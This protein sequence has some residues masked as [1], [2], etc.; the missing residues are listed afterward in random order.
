[1]LN[2]G[3]TAK[4]VVAGLS[5]GLAVA[6]TAVSDGSLSPGEVVGIVAAVLGSYGITWRVP[7][8]AE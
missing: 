8:S 1:M 2:V 6:V 5:A 3:S 7:N 4:A